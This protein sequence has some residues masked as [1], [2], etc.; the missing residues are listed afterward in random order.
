LGDA[1]GITTLDQHV[2]DAG[3]AQARMLI[4]NLPDEG[5][6]RVV[7]GSPHGAG[8]STEAIGFNGVAH[9]VG[10]YL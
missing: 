6:V 5:Q 2:V 3:S 1:A 9:G 8:V 10:M 4:Q 7:D